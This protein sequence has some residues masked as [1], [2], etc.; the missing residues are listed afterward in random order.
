[1]REGEEREVKSTGGVCC[2]YVLCVVVRVIVLRPSTAFLQH[3]ITRISLLVRL[4]SYH[5]PL[6]A[7][8]RT[9]A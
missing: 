9:T 3:E 7:A 4:A 2:M 6:V 5:W 8:P 1:V